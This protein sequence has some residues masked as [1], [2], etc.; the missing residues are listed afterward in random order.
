MNHQYG[1]HG[2]FVVL[3]DAS[4]EG[5]DGMDPFSNLRNVVHDWNLDN[6]AILSDREGQARSM[7]EITR[8][9]TTLVID[10]HRRV[11]IRWEGLAPPAA[12]ATAVKSVL[13]E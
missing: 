3:I 4:A 8:L 5:R 2:L 7:F 9:P 1:P 13:D 11:V 12:L 10:R 6:L